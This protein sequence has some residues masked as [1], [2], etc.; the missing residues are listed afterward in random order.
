M[1]HFCFHKNYQFSDRKTFLNAQLSKIPHL[2]KFEY[3]KTS[4]KAVKSKSWKMNKKVNTE[5]NRTFQQDHT[6]KELS[7]ALLANKLWLL[8]ILLSSILNS[9]KVT[10]IGRKCVK[11]AWTII[12]T[13]LTH[14]Q[15]S[16]NLTCSYVHSSSLILEKWTAKKAISNPNR[17]TEQIIRRT[18]W[19]SIRSISSGSTSYASFLFLFMPQ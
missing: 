3:S 6:E 9:L 5:I 11:K 7:G 12:S 2:A 17:S 18:Y 15:K 13:I 14:L 10:K 8:L 19:F 1:V 4:Q 16:V